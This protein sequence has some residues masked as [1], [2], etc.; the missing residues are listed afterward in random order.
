MEEW[1]SMYIKLAQK[2]TKGQICDG[3]ISQNTFMRC[4]KLTGYVQSFM[5]LSRSAQFSFLEYLLY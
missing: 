2:V 5:L 3:S 4:T 1:D